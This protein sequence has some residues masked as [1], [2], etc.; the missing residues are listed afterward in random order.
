M[1]KRILIIIAALML[2]LSV[3]HA[4]RADR[5]NQEITDSAKPVA[6]RGG[7]SFA[8]TS[9]FDGTFD[10]VVRA[11]KKA[12]ESV[13]VADRE[14]GLIATEIT[15]AGGWRQTGTRTVVSL[16]KES[17]AETT[18]KVAVTVQKR[19]KA[20]QVEPWSD[21]VLDKEKTNTAAADLK[22]AIASK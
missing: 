21:P 4:S 3:A 10:A 19:F 18:V 5:K 16:I 15:V 6:V 2:S 9:A 20:L 13:V 7:S 12:D 17:D 1:H 8:V 22:A 14:T 11:L